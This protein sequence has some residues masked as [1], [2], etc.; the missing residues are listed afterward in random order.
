[1]PL[2]ARL[3]GESG[4]REGQR[5][6]REEREATHDPL[7]IAQAG[8]TLGVTMAARKKNAYAPRLA[9]LAKELAKASPKKI[10][11]VLFDAFEIVAATGDVARTRT[12][13]DWMYG[14]APAP[15][16]VASALSTQAIDGF[17]AAAKLGDRTAGLPQHPRSEVAQPPLATRVKAAGAMAR[18]RVLGNSYGGEMPTDD[19][20]QKLKPSDAWRAIDRWR[21]IQALAAGGEEREALERLDALLEDWSADA[22]GAGYGDELVLALDLALRNGKEARIPAWLE[23]HGVRFADEAFLI[24]TAL[25]LPAVAAFIAGGGL[26]DVI[27]LSDGDLAT[28]MKTLDAAFPAPAAQ[29][30]A[31]TKAPKVQK[32]RVSAEYSQVHLGPET[33]TEA[34][35]AQVHFQKKTDSERGMSLFSTMVGIATPNETDYV[36]AEIT[37]SSSAKVDLSGVAQA[38]SFPLE[39]RGPLLLSSVSGDDDDPLSIPNGS[40]DVLARFVAKKAPKASAEAGLRVF[41]LLLSFHP[42]GSLGAPK[43]LEMAE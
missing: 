13:I 39:V 18:E 34:E 1:M 5:T 4:G 2:D 36:D 7:T 35:K 14:R 21:R 41:S 22:R 26:R 30:A 10:H 23:R 31:P 6:E 28:A 17:C 42:A 33:L 38:V 16:E 15:L 3:A 29:K 37:L 20:W 25:C 8:G 27:G 9:R 24:Q 19:S 40:Y 12:L 43:T 11:R 32:R